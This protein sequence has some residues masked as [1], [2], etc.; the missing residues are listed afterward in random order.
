MRKILTVLFLLPLSSGPVLA[1]DKEIILSPQEYQQVLAAL[2]SKDPVMAFLMKK[3]SEAQ[4]KTGHS[5]GVPVP[6][7]E[8]AK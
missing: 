7:K 1:Q 5:T 4:D 2:A 8:S 6:G 3:Q